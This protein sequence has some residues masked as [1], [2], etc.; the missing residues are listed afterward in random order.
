VCNLTQKETEIEIRQ[1]PRTP[2][3]VM[4]QNT[5][6]ILHLLLACA[7]HLVI[8]PDLLDLL[9][10]R[11]GTGLE[12]EL[13]ELGPADELGGVGDVVRLEGG[14]DGVALLIQL[15]RDVRRPGHVAQHHDELV[16]YNV[17]THA[18]ATAVAEDEH[19][20][21]V[22]VLAQRLLVCGILGVQPPIWIEGFRV[23]VQFGVPRDRPCTVLVLK[24]I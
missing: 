2:A 4:Q 7:S 1:R 10:S 3:Y 8:L 23:R 17:L 11:L 22:R 9:R 5:I 13:E 21:D 16:L 6:Q 18:Q 14:D 12:I 19:V 15:L 24:S 20:S